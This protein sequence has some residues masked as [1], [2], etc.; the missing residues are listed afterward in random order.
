MSNINQEKGKKMK[1]MVKK[2]LVYPYDG[3][4]SSGSDADYEKPKEIKTN[5]KEE[6]MLSDLE[7]SAKSL[8]RYIN[9]FYENG[10]KEIADK[11]YDVVDFIQEQIK[12]KRNY[13]SIYK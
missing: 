3:Y 9:F 7:M 6:S 5:T 10:D 1:T 4:S 12:Q 13:K 11:V 8:E 2:Y